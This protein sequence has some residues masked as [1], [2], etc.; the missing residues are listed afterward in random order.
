[1]G[2]AM[3]PSSLQS[4]TIGHCR[5][6]TTMARLRE[7]LQGKGFTNAL[8]MAPQTSHFYTETCKAE[9]EPSYVPTP[10]DPEV[11][12]YGCVGN[13]QK[14]SEADMQN[15]IK[16][17]TDL[18]HFTT[19]AGLGIPRTLLVPALYETGDAVHDEFT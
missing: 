14:T 9:L 18:P 1:M 15:Y 17:A 19:M 10:T 11:S 7:A 5:A 2:S 12:V 4:S 8:F 13:D 16:C 6:W 3:A